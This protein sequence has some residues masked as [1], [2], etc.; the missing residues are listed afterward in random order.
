MT[1][2]QKHLIEYIFYK[3]LIRNG[4][5]P[6]FSFIHSRYKEDDTELLQTFVI[7]ENKTIA[8]FDRVYAEPDG[9]V[10]NYELLLA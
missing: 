7:K 3:E 6:K 2:K 10:M 1:R 4:I 9:H 5:T 8:V